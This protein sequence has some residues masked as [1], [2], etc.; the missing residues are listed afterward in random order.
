MA[1]VNQSIKRMRTLNQ[2]PPSTTPYPSIHAGTLR[3]DPHYVDPAKIDP[4]LYTDFVPQLILREGHEDWVAFDRSAAPH[5]F[6]VRGLVFLGGC[7]CVGVVC[8][9]PIHTAKA[10][11]QNTT[12][13]PPPK[14]TKTNTNINIYRRRSSPPFR[15]PRRSGPRRPRSWW[16]RGRIKRRWRRRGR[17]C[18]T[19]G[20]WVGW[21]DVDGRSRPL[22]SPFPTHLHSHTRTHVHADTD[23]LTISL[24]HQTPHPP[25]KCIYSEEMPQ[26]CC[27]GSFSLAGLMAWAGDACLVRG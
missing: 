7:M 12:P 19:S 25:T 20:G 3:G 16:R 22:C 2:R 4:S 27:L 11:I 14:K 26:H 18:A 10:K 6:T 13:H 9:G 24:Y 1:L 17:R 8:R 5:Y 23:T 21:M 15:P